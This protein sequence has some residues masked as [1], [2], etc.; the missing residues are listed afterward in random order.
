PG[1]GN[2]SML[3]QL[4]AE[5]MGIPLDRVRLYTRDTGNTAA[6]GPAAGSRVTYMIGY[7]L[8]NALEQLRAVM[9]ETGAKSGPELEA[10]GRPKRYVGRK[11]NEDAGPLDAKTGQGPSFESQV[12]AVQMVELE[13][14]TDTGKVKILKMTTA[15]DA[16]P[17]INPLNLTGQLEG[18]MDMG[19]GYALREEYVAGRTKDW[20]TFKFP[21][22]R[23]SF[24]TEI[25][26]HETPRPK[27]PLGAT[28]VGEMCMV[29]TA[30]AVINAIRNA[31]GVWVTE[32]PAT[33]GKVKAALAADR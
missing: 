11:K 17:V 27:G 4:T 19:V 15:V 7:A 14:D 6:S 29:P 16:G 21:T 28:G 8:L 18:G 32:L 1:E 20:V 26:I 5:F 22:I 31:I 3:T 25:I 13:V 24:D 23:D 12:H 9:R 30:P 10:A 33:P 2:D